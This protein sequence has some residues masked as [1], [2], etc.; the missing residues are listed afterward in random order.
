M[1]STL[2]STPH[3]LVARDGPMTALL[4]VPAARCRL[5]LT[6][7]EPKGAGGVSSAGAWVEVVAPTNPVVPSG[8]SP[9]SAV[10]R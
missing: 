10:N 4:P 9:V 8:S 6:V 5:H 1:D 2:H 3:R 7:S